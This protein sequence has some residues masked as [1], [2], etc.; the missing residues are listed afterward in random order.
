MNLKDKINPIVRNIPPS[1]IRRFFDIASEM[2]DAISL[3][4]GEPDFITPCSVRQ[5]GIYSLEQ[6][7]THYTSNWGLDELREE[8]AKYLLRKY[9]ITYSPK[10]E[11]IVTVGGSEAIDI[12]LRA[13]AG[14]G[15][16]VLIQQPCF[17]SYRP[18]VEFTGAKPVIISTREEENFKIIPIQIE[19]MITP[20]SKILLMSYPNNPTGATMTKEE[21]EAI[22]KVVK[23]HDLLVISDEIYSELTYEGRHTSIASLPGMRDRTV[24]IN[25]FSKAFAMTGWRMGYVAGHR[26]II[27]AMFKVHQYA[28]MCSPTTAQYAAI[29]ALR[30]CDD[31]V[32]RMKQEYN[33]RRN[34]IEL[35]LKKAGLKCFKPMGAFYAFPSIKETGLSSEQFCEKLLKEEKVAVVPGSA[36][37][38][39][40]EGYIRISYA[41]SI[42]TINLAIERIERFMNSL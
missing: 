35:G 25:G 6:G 8:I 34:V 12:A 10:D 38:E 22:A 21:L 31:E 17:V 29:E 9:E 19:D 13:L 2:K 40:G 37:G 5:A 27:E 30:N 11:I 41:Y 33:R 14:P 28:I 16:E 7:Q 15:D 1:G 26:D 4:I 20:K 32:E 18:C 39:A 3:G 24:V 42:E 23:K 36:F